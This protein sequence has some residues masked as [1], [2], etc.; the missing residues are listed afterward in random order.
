MKHISIFLLSLLM[1]CV[2]CD[3]S[4]HDDIDKQIAVKGDLIYKSIAIFDGKP[5]ALNFEVFLFDKYLQ[6]IAPD[7]A[8]D[9][10][11][12]RIL[13]A[14][15]AFGINEIQGVGISSELVTQNLVRNRSFVAVPRVGIF[16]ML[17]TKEMT[18]E[19]FA[20]LAPK[21]AIV[22]SAMYI[23][24]A[25]MSAELRKTETFASAFD[26]IIA[27]TEVDFLSKF[28][29][30]K[31]LIFIVA[32]EASEASGELPIPIPISFYLTM[33]FTAPPAEL[34]GSGMDEFEQNE[35]GTFTLNP[36]HVP[37]GKL[38]LSPDGDGTKLEVFYGTMDS[39][40]KLTD[41]DIF[42][43]YAALLA[44]RKGMGASFI[45]AAELMKVLQENTEMPFD[46]SREMPSQLGIACVSKSGILSEAITGEDM[47][48]NEAGM[49][50]LVTIATMITPTVIAGIE[51]GVMA[52]E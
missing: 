20:A 52:E 24:L 40:E 9:V 51:R 21:N 37:T 45:N 5:R 25:A 49:N 15:L 38:L 12:R 30:Q 41:N 13:E 32:P 22:A 36:E 3:S 29:A 2:A 16:N 35:D 46:I 39:S 14:A 31:P 6:K 7:A 4:I 42:K 10:T 44:C 43:E 18:I 19:E 34:I 11:R 26:R 48:A 28:N 27:E 17:G 33:S 23:D 8:P 50:T 1:L 47:I